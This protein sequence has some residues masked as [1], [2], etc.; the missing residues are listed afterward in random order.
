[1][2]GPDKT[3]PG[4]M[5]TDPRTWAVLAPLMLLTGWYVLF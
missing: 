5:L 2:P 1:M 4:P 3:K